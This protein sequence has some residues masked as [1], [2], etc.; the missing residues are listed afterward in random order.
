ML[1]K[2]K[3]GYTKI[4]CKELKTTPTSNTKLLLANRR[5]NTDLLREA[6]QCIGI[7]TPAE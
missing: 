7:N 5:T 6:I 3:P 1:N 2:T 4:H